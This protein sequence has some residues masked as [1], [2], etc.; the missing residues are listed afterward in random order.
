MITSILLSIYLAGMPVSLFLLMWALEG[1][2]TEEWESL[3]TLQGFAALVVFTL[4]WPFFLAVNIYDVLTER[5]GH[6]F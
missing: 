5:S 6:D 3:L 1:I 4:L 2:P